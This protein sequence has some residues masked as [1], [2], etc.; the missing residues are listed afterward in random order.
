MNNFL[1]YQKVCETSS[2]MMTK[3]YSTSF[4]RACLLFNVEIRQHIYNIYG[5]V[6]LTDEI[7][8]TFHD[9]NKK[10]LLEKFEN[11]YRD[12]LEEGIS[13]NPIIHSFCKTQVENSIPQNLVDAFLESMKMDLRPIENLNRKEFNSYIY[14]SAEVVGL[15]CLKTFV[16]GNEKEY[17]TLKPYAQ[18]LGAAFQK[19][20][21]LRD[22]S[23]DFH[24]LNRTYFPNVDFSKFTIQD[25]KNIEKEIEHDFQHALIGI[26]KLAI[27]SRLAVF[28]AYKYYFNLFKKIRKVKPEQLLKKRIRV[29]NARKMVLF[30]EMFLSHN[31][32]LIR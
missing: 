17:E 28:M 27:S 12:A 8:D 6:R 26:K 22:L 23:S 10:K 31:F 9:F 13:N 18:S 7:V 32:N 14:G 21:F 2:K 4:S 16:K 15:M 5:F 25:K 3:K 30:G 11:D 19:I 1:L 20:N 29:S 24:Q